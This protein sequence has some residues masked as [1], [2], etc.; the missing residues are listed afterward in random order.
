MENQFYKLPQGIF[1]EKYSGISSDGKLLYALMLD[2]M[3][4]SE[5]NGW[6]DGHGRVYIIFTREEACRVLG[7]GKDKAARVYSEL[8]AAG[9]I[10]QKKQYLARPT[11]I[12]VN[13]ISG[14]E[15]GSSDVVG[16]SVQ[17]AEKSASNAGKS[18]VQADGKAASI[19][20]YHNQNENSQLEN[21]KTY[22]NQTGVNDVTG[23]SDSTNLKEHLDEVLELDTLKARYP[24]SAGSLEEIRDIIAEVI[25]L[26]RRVTFEGRVVPEKTAA[27]RFRKLTSEN[28]CM[29][30]DA[31][32]QTE[33]D[34]RR[35]D[36]YIAT[37]LYG[38]TFTVMSRNEVG[39]KSLG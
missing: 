20:T 38:S 10:E 34:I 23:I 28:I 6:C 15:G 8:E 14:R 25:A 26:R 7:F 29:V 3:K 4:L 9:L 2:R 5:M 22:P 18:K 33:S 37:A 12:Y 17:S 36:A 39:W 21:I 11:L 13:E 19:K 27:E 30:L 35:I 32:S 16:D 31:L 1:S 24:L